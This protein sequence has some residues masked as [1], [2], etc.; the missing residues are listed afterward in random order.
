VALKSAVVAVVAKS[1]EG[2]VESV[3]LDVGRASTV[4][5]QQIETLATSESLAQVSVLAGGLHSHFH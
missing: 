4:V 2:M 1:Y 5:L 3:V